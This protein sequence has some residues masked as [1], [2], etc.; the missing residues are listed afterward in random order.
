MPILLGSGPR[1][2]YGRVNKSE[3]EFH[4]RAKCEADK[5]C[6]AFTYK[7]SEGVCYLKSKMNPV[8]GTDC[9][10]G[11]WFFGA[12]P[13]PTLLIHTPPFLMRHERLCPLKTLSP[14]DFGL[15]LMVT[16]LQE[17]SR[18]AWARSDSRSTHCSSRPSNRALIS[19]PLEEQEERWGR[20]GFQTG[21]AMLPPRHGSVQPLLCGNSER[22]P[23]DSHPS[24]GTATFHLVISACP[25]CP[26]S[27]VYLQ[28]C[29][30]Y[31]KAFMS[32]W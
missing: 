19:P 10:E 28:T 6:V 32:S 3:L 11:C 7:P 13:A 5:K 24:A 20:R 29:K 25:S 27:L 14:A 15:I 31:G 9:E 1:G 18:T 4:C 12:M 22:D 16:R 21:S 30:L 26:E 8:R 17:W 23:T 2:E